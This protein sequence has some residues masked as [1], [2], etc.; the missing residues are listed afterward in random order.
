[1]NSQLKF[2][3]TE[4]NNAD[5]KIKYGLQRIEQKITKGSTEYSIL[6]NGIDLTKFGLNL[7]S[8]NDLIDTFGSPFD[9]N[10]VLPFNIKIP[11][12]YKSTN[13]KQ[14]EKDKVPDKIFEL[15]SFKTWFYIFYNNI[16]DKEAQI[17]AASCL[18]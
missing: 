8:Q 15:L 17:K 10:F 7:N 11:K 9:N 13:D 2:N 1:M 16:E 12:S 18:Y 14:K 3:Q 5:F 4:E 6:T